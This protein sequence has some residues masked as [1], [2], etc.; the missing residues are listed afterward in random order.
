[1]STPDSTFSP[2]CPIE[3][4]AEIMGRN[5]YGVGNAMAHFKFFPPAEQGRSLRTA[6]FSPE[7]LKAC[8]ETHLLVLCAPLSL[9]GVWEKQSKLFC[10]KEDPWYAN[11]KFAAV[12]AELGWQLVRKDC[13]PDSLEK[14]WA[15]Q[16]KLLSE[17]EEVSSPAVLAQAILLHFLETGERLFDRI[18][19]RTSST[20]SV[21]D[22]VVLG[23][24]VG[25][26]LGVSR[27]LDGNSDSGIGLSSAWKL[28]EP[29]KS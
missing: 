17:Q 24:F 29:L 22:H 15:E 4:A 26:G 25:H 23:C 3:Q 13:L 27:Y 5:I 7:V 16:L 21:G 11:E 28:M 14:T 19:V 20:D 1:M 2:T 12:P 6:P 10:T 8:N 9:M 18:Y